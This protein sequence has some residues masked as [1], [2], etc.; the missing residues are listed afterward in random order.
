MPP[1][2]PP[3]PLPPPPSPT[4]PAFPGGVEND[5]AAS[6]EVQIV[7]DVLPS[8]SPGPKRLRIS[9]KRAGLPA[10]L[11]AGDQ[12]I[13]GFFNRISPKSAVARVL[14]QSHKKRSEL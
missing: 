9:P 13:T 4:P 1:A 2:P 8:F 11:R 5:E 7:A 14:A 12:R 6:P 3:A 10:A